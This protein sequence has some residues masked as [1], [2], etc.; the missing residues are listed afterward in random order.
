MELTESQKRFFYE[1]GYLKVS[2]AVPRAM[3]DAARQAINAEIGKGNTNTSPDI[4]YAVTFRT[5]HTQI[6]EIGLDAFT[7]IWR[8]WDGVRETVGAV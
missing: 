2:G 3:V 5:K 8:E 1:E 7:D 6:D 4:R